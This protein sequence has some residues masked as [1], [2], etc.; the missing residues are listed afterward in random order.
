MEQKY[1]NKLTSR[2][3]YNETVSMVTHHGDKF[4]SPS[5]QSAPL[6]EFLAESMTSILLQKIQSPVLV[7]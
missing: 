5:L 1:I 2:L 7:E 4:F 3:D 6:F